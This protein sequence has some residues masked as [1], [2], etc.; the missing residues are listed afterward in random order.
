MAA[1]PSVQTATI[2]PSKPPPSIE[3]TRPCTRSPLP[4]TAIRRE[5]SNRSIDA[6]SARCSRRSITPTEVLVGRIGN[7][8]FSTP[9]SMPLEIR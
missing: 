2:S 9:S 8:T 5:V 6:R 3:L 4:W 7:S 1:Q